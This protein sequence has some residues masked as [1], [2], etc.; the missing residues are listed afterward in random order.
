[1][2]RRQTGRDERRCL[3]RRTPATLLHALSLLGR[4]DRGDGKSLSHGVVRLFARL[5]DRRRPGES[6][7][8][9]YYPQGYLD[10]LAWARWRTAAC[11]PHPG[12]FGDSFRGLNATARGLRW[13]RARFRDSQIK[14]EF[15]HS[16]DEGTQGAPRALVGA[17]LH[18]EAGWISLVV[19]STGGP[20]AHLRWA[21]HL[22]T[23][24]TCPCDT[25]WRWTFSR[26]SWQA[27]DGW[28]PLRFPGLRFAPPSGRAPRPRRR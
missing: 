18:L 10:S 2:R 8:R 22:A 20:V 16:T 28:L 21:V 11:G 24:I 9:Q 26:S 17:V 23:S 6:G 4:S 25:R 1:M 13:V 27:G 15:V 5:Y 3:R 19:G 12:L 14:V 7:C